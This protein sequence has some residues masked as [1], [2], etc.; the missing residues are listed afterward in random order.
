MS[1]AA[2]LAC[3]RPMQTAVPEGASRG[4]CRIAVRVG[5]RHRVLARIDDPA[6]LLGEVEARGTEDVDEVVPNVAH[7]LAGV[8]GGWG[9]DGDRRAGDPLVVVLTP[10]GQA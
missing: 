2:V 3:P 8:Q 1:P 4:S 6:F 10:V 9:N 7:G 5:C